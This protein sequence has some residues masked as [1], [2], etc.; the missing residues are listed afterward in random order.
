MGI[1]WLVHKAQYTPPQFRQWCLRKNVVN[2]APPVPVGFDLHFTDIQIFVSLSEIHLRATR[3]HV[4]RP[5]Q[6]ML[7]TSLSIGTPISSRNCTI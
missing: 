1:F 6:R 4:K 7:R 3:A 2:N 5:P